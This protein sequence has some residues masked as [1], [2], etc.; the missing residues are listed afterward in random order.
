[1]ADIRVEVDRDRFSLRVYEW[2]DETS[3]YR[4]KA[5]YKVALGAVN[6][7][8]PLGPYKVVGRSRTPDWKA[9]SWAEGGVAG[10]IA[11]FWM[12]DYELMGLE[13]MPEGFIPPDVPNIAKLTDDGETIPN[14]AN[15]F[16]GGF[17]ALGGHPSTR[18][19]GVGF[20]GTKFDP[21]L[22]TRASHG[23]IRMA[24]PDFL[25]FWMKISPG[26]PVT[27]HGNY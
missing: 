8:T 4:R 1:M 5:S 12:P 25:N 17:I 14:P 18:G 19:D 7:A 22:G 20:H 26:T 6:F 10:L 11:P 27:V 13:G 23:C 16:E 15:P 24:V 21:Q 2:S 9:P 3:R